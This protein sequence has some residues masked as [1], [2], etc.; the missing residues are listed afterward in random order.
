MSEADR[1][2]PPKLAK[3]VGA[4]HVWVPKGQ[5]GQ[6][7]EEAAELY[8]AHT[9]GH[10]VDANREFFARGQWAWVR[11]GDLVLGGGC[12]EVGRCFYWRR[13]P[14]GFGGGTLPSADEIAD[15]FHED[16]RGPLVAGLKEW[17]EWAC[18]TPHSDLDWRDLF[19]W[20]QRIA[21]WLSAIEQALD[22]MDSDRFYPVN[23]S[24][25]FATLLRLPVEKRL[26]SR[27]HIDLI[28]RMAPELLQLPFNRPTRSCK[29]SL[30][31]IGGILTR[32]LGLWLIP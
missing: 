4:K 7:S 1:T 20:E 3:E 14:N 6:Y 5:Y 2:L 13:F 28:E 10:A 29:R 15:G 22:L 31:R 18:Q 19:Y 8:D 17:V 30:Q 26:V 9:G 16:S 32:R 25:T 27:H 23:S 12:F 21:G 11:A 24:H